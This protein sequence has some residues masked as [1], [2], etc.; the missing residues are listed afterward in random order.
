M[1][2]PRQAMTGSLGQFPNR[3]PVR[4]P[5]MLGLMHGSHTRGYSTGTLPGESGYGV[6][7]VSGNGLGAHDMMMCGPVSLDCT[8]S[9]INKKN[10]R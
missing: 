3:L 5:Y 2:R 8:T 4:N 9:T 6:S 1:N 7:V 10:I